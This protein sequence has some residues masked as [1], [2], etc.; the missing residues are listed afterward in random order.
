MSTRRRRAAAAVYPPP[1]RTFVEGEGLWLTDAEGSRSSTSP[2]GSRSSRSATAIPAP[3]AAAHAQLDRLWHCSNLFGTEPPRSWP[4]RLSDRFGGAQAFFCNSGAE[5]NEAALKYARKATGTPGRD[6]ARGQLPRAHDRR[7]RRDRPA[8][9]AR[10]LRAAAPRTS[11][12]RS[13]TTSTRCAPRP[14][15]TSG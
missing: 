13:P 12:S 9:E 3:L 2:A 15:A 7:A 4:R 11:A 6:R 1:E 10:R 8:R 14:A 5:A